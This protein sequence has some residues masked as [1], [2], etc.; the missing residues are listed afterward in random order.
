[1]LNH[2]NSY[3]SLIIPIFLVLV[4]S[5]C[6]NP[7]EE[8]YDSD[9]RLLTLADIKAEYR[10]VDSLNTL[11]FQNELDTTDL[12]RHIVL[13]I[14]SRN[15]HLLARRCDQIRLMGCLIYQN[16]S[17]LYYD[18]C[19]STQCEDIDGIFIIDYEGFAGIPRFIGCSPDTNQ[20][21]NEPG[22]FSDKF[23]EA[24][25]DSDHSYISTRTVR[26][27]DESLD[28]FITG[29]GIEETGLFLHHNIADST[30]NLHVMG[31]C[32]TVPSYTWVKVTFNYLIT[33]IAEDTLNSIIH[34]SSTDT[35]MIN[36]Q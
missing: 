16:V 3:L 15:D 2:H 1:M 34:Y 36:K 23:L 13:G 8:N 33:P 35:L 25:H 31:F 32:G 9:Y 4:V 24:G 21:V 29:W 26:Q 22:R 6:E 30:L 19:D 28:V 7:D 27:L 17:G 11:S 18:D 20:T 14:D 5:S 10:I 12:D